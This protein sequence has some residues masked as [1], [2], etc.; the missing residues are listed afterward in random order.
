MSTLIKFVIF[1]CP[2]CIKQIEMNIKPG[3]T[4]AQLAE[5][6]AALPAV[7]ASARQIFVTN[8]V[9]D[10]KY[11]SD[12]YVFSGDEKNVLFVEALAGG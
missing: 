6:C 9:V 2:G 1:D 8:C 4:K 5:K 12:K 3:T 7:T 10:G 11:Q